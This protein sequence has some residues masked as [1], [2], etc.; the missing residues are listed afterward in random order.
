[1]RY[2]RFAIARFFVN[3]AIACIPDGAGTLKPVVLL[4]MANDNIKKSIAAL[5]GGE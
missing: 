5:K 1:M 4:M 3:L 2:T